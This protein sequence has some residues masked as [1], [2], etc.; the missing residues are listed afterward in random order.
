[1]IGDVSVEPL[2]VRALGFA[3]IYSSLNFVLFIFML[4]RI[5]LSHALPLRFVDDDELN[6]ARATININKLRVACVNAVS[7]CVEM[8]FFLDFFLFS[9][10]LLVARLALFSLLLA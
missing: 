10:P 6:C 2:F 4:E 9:L 8:R 7:M 1:M 3:S 5:Q